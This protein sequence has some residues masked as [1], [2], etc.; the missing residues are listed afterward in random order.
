MN[1]VLA[2][3]DH[4]YSFGAVTYPK[5]GRYGPMEQCYAMLLMIESGTATIQI[6]DCHH[7][8]REN[9]I[10]CTVN[11]EPVTIH[12]PR[13]LSTRTSWCEAHPNAL[14]EHERKSIEETP[15]VITL[16][17]RLQTLF[18]LGIDLGV[19]PSTKTNELRNSL[20]HACFRAFIYESNIAV[21]EEPIPNSF[22]Q[23]RLYIEERFL[24]DCS[25]PTLAKVVGISAQHLTYG[26]N[27]YFGITPIRYV[28]Q[29]RLSQG[30]GLLR[31]SG[32]SV[33]EIAYQ[34][35]YQNPYHFS[36]Q[37]KEKY[38]S[39]PKQLRLKKGF[40]DPSFDMENITDLIY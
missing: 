34:C 13:E 38:G 26:F 16:S 21:E 35:G 11:H 6:G 4:G 29:L 31:R 9:Q 10:A 23:A 30:V 18:K 20:G 1:S 14:P 17:K 33:S 27:R 32:L 40:Q 39:S 7:A 25:L 2:T 5:G 28:W 19:I 8:V 3:D 37:V 22:K 36:R 24:E 12:C 15:R